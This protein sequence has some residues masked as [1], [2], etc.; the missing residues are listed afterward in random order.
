[1]G[2][3]Q[4]HSLK[5]TREVLSMRNSKILLMVGLIAILVLALPAFAFAAD[6]GGLETFESAEVPTAVAL[7][8][9]WLLVAAF[10]VFLMQA[11]FA[12]VEAGFCRAK[13]T[14]NLMMKNMMDM[15]MGSIAY[16]VI[17][18]GLMYG[19]DAAGLIGTDGWLMA[20]DFYDVTMYRDFM[21]QVVFAATAATIVSGA[22]AERLKFSAYLV[23]SIALT[24]IIY[25]IYGHWVWGGGWL[26]NRSVSATS[27]SPD[28][29]SSTRSVVSSVSPAPSCLVLASASSARTASLAPSRVTTSRLR[30]SACSSSGSAGSD[31]TRARRC[32][33]LICV[34]PSSPSTRTWLRQLVLSSRSSSPSSRRGYGISAWASTARSPA[35]SAS[36]L[37]VRSS[38]VPT[39]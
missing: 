31:S 28:Q 33:V 22:V 24:A 26:A 20:G 1:M 34:W 17:G 9:I 4:T 27:T 37:H 32:P 5:D 12:A 29:A 30:R 36:P 23:Y 10:L 3:T 16:F 13:N 11:G 14:T 38:V 21:F 2:S 19:A 39:R 25:P 35:S 7:D 6:A 8:F 15:A 18:F